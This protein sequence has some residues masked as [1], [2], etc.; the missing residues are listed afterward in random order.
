MSRL[1][2]VGAMIVLL[3][4]CAEAGQVK[5]QPTLAQQQYLQSQ[6]MEHW[7]KKLE[8][9]DFRVAYEALYAMEALGPDKPGVVPLLAKAV[10]HRDPGIRGNALNVLARF[11]KSAKAAVPA[12]QAATHDTDTLVRIDAAR[13]LWAMAKDLA[14]IPV[15]IDVLKHAD[16]SHRLLAAEALG[17]IGPAA[18][19]ALPDLPPL[20]SA[21]GLQTRIFA[22]DAMS[23]IGGSSSE[24]LPP[25]WQACRDRHYQVRCAAAQ[26]LGKMGPKAKPC[27][28]ILIQLLGD[29]HGT[30]RVAAAEALWNI[31]GRQE[32]IARIAAEL[33]TDAQTPPRAVVY[34]SPQDPMPAPSEY[35]DDAQTDSPGYVHQAAVDALVRIA[36]A[37][38]QAAAVLRDLKRQTQR[39][40]HV[41]AA[42]ALGKV[43]PN[44]DPLP[45]L[46]AALTNARYSARIEAA[47]ALQEMGPKAKAAAAAVLEALHVFAAEAPGVPADPDILAALRANFEMNSHLAHSQAWLNTLSALRAIDP[48]TAATYESGPEYKAWR[49]YIVRP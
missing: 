29:L 46:T 16:E 43:A 8:S 47:N 26:A 3:L 21:A 12:V 6:P 19:E 7:A 17:K 15:L 31:E 23:K 2:N 35:N 10:T 22:V 42:V 44:E 18:K 27:V 30:A 13:A 9:E 24:L 41:Q 14:A 40:V 28:P 49:E 11:G 4:V 25:L 48:K 34:C 36:P 5:A 45:T 37:T 32:A 20:L 38:P 1:M 39:S 33:A